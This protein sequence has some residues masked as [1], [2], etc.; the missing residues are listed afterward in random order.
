[1]AHDPSKTEKATPKR[2]AEAR[3]RGQVARSPEVNQTA[4]FAGG[5]I[6]LAISGPH[7]FHA[8]ESI[9]SHGLAQVGQPSL[10]S[11]D[12][13]GDVGRWAFMATLGALAPVL[14][15]T[16]VAGVL[17]NVVQ[18]RPKVTF[19]AIKPTFSKIDPRTGFKR[20]VS[21]HSL[22]ETGKQLAKLAVIGGVTFFAV[23]PQLTSLGGLVGL[24][25]SA[26]PGK[27][28]GIV[29][30]IALRAIVPLTVIAVADLVV[31]RRRLEK[32][33]R[34]T[35]DEVK[36]EHR[37]QDLPPEVRGKLRQKQAEQAR[38]RMLAEVPT[39]DVV[40]VNPTH[41]A[42]AL[43][44]DGT[45]PAPEVVAKGVDHVA[46][47]IRRVATEHD[48]PI[49]SNPPL[50]RQLYADVEIGHMIPEQFY[51]AVAEVLAWVFR[52]ARRGLMARA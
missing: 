9:V 41:Y 17:A 47:S 8:L 48:V 25:P 12:G 16:A 18:V 38:K 6:A 22:L 19:R 33:L 40:I 11:K 44:Y 4:V 50:A 24:P 23:Y 31:A 21:P 3:K 29:L 5:V 32:S 30:S 36:R 52:T 10:T 49:L 46:A 39:A 14:I 1:M 2:R 45:R 35:K 20:L 42:V 27:I 26:L 43:R 34:M 28:G 7:I 51:A 37:E 13:L 15:A